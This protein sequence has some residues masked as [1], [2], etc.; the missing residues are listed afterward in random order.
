MKRIDCVEVFA[1]HR[2]DAIV[3]VSPGYTG[4]ELHAAGHDEATIYNMD[5][6]Y[7]SPMCLGIA[8]AQ[9]EQRVVAFEGDGSMLMALG[10]LTTIGRYQPRNLA[11]VVFHN[12]VYLTTGDGSV[13]T[14]DADFTAMARAAG[15]ERACVVSELPAFEQAI[16]QALTEPGP[17]FI[18]ARVDASDR[19]D[20]RARG[21]L[22]GDLVEQA[23]L[24]QKAM[25]ERGIATSGGGH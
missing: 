1:R 20:P 14:A 18:Q 6:P 13:P 11:V 21:E 9:P 25:R 10:T 4:H 24:F 3:I 12:A 5:M 22:P 17:W 19:G 15:I 8:L 16:R 2:G 7:T 23:M